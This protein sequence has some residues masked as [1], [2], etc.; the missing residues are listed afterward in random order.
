ME[1]EA[2]EE[3]KKRNYESECDSDLEKDDRK[4]LEERYEK[5]MKQQAKTII[6]PISTSS[7]K[8][9]KKS[10]GNFKVKAQWTRIY[11]AIQEHFTSHVNINR[12]SHLLPPTIYAMKQTSKQAWLLYKKRECERRK[13]LRVKLEG[14]KEKEKLGLEPANILLSLVDSCECCKKLYITVNLFWGITLCDICYFN[15]DVISEIMR[16]RKHAMGSSNSA[17]SRSSEILF[18]GSNRVILEG[19]C[20]MDE[21]E[22]REAEMIRKYYTVEEEKKPEEEESLL[23]AKPIRR[24]KA[25]PHNIKGDN[26]ISSSSS[27]ETPLIIEV[28]DNQEDDD[29]FREVSTYVSPPLPPLITTHHQQ[30]EEPSTSNND[31][32]YTSE[33]LSELAGDID[34]DFGI[35]SEDEMEMYRA[36]RESKQ[37]SFFK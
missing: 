26:V 3:S 19:S 25:S 36:R 23:P 1:I 13:R 7:K 6:G 30:H 34:F 4:V 5:F 27:P 9:K 21:K 16:D 14:E 37:L 32:Y 12:V 31:Y 33:G 20:E 24:N 35:D 18:S 10:R 2:E 17:T 28:G 8:K 11:D 29:D 15:S 22:K